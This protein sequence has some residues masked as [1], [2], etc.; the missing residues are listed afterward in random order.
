MSARHCFLPWCQEDTYEYLGPLVEMAV[1]RDAFPLCRRHY[2]AL[3]PITEKGADIMNTTAGVRAEADTYGAAMTATPA[4]RFPS[5]GSNVLYKSRT[6][7]YSLA[8]KVARNCKSSSPE[9]LHR[10]TEAGRLFMTPLT[11][12]QVDLCVFTPGGSHVE[13][14]PSQWTGTYAEHHIEYDPDGRPGTWRWFEDAWVRGE[15]L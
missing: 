9:A 5:L 7:D 8:A 12:L 2:N 13:G 10:A 15:E 11:L 14:E 1:D 3:A 4:P 6:G